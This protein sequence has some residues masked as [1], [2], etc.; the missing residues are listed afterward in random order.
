MPSFNAPCRDMNNLNPAEAAHMNKVRQILQC[1][2]FPFPFYIADHLVSLVRTSDHREE[3]D[4]RL[5]E[6]L[7]GAR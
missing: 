5:Y 2:A 6:A 7:L 4:A 3:A 1:N